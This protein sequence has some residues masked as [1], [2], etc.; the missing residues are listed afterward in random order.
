VAWVPFLSL[1]GVRWSS[2]VGGGGR[3]PRRGSYLTAETPARL[4]DRDGR[5]TC[6]ESVQSVTGGATSSDLSQQ[7]VLG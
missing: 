5:P 7:K 3:R 4:R 1:F 6:R 2:R